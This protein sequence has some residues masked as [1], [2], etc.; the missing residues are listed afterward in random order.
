MSFILD[1]L[2][3]SEHERQ[4][5]AM[6]GVAQVPFGLPRRELPTWAT[7]L[8]VVLVVALLALGGAWWRA[9]RSDA[10]AT[11]QANVHGEV[12]LALPAPAS[13][14]ARAPTEGLPPP[15]AQ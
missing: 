13:S 9:A 5:A 6:P 15:A 3:K 12:P 8:I 11:T 14:A 2:R 10:T 1:A 4:R 7:A